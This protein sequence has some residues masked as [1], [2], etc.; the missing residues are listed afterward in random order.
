MEEEDEID[1]NDDFEVEGNPGF[2]DKDL[3][4]FFDD[5]KYLNSFLLIMKLNQINIVY[6]V[7]IS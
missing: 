5:D 7:L 2:I 3:D 6:I 1:E 4:I